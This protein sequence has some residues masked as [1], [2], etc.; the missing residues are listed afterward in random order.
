MDGKQG[1]K[2]DAGP[3]GERGDIGPVIKGE[4][5]EYL[6]LFSSWLMRTAW[7]DKSGS[8]FPFY[9]LIYTRSLIFYFNNTI[10]NLHKNFC[11]QPF[12]WE[13]HLA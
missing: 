8:L 12:P 10:T 5:G 7:D 11:V 3:E 9:F 13:F 1:Q 2:G 4:K 6:F